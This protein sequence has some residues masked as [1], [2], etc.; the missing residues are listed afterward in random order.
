MGIEQY[1]LMTD[2]ALWEV[3]LNGDSPVSTRTV[4]GV[5]TAIPPTT[6]EQKLAKRNELNLT[7]QLDNDDLKQIDPDDLEEMDLKWQMTMLTIRARRFLKKNGRNL[8]V[9]GTNTIS[10]DKTKSNQ[11]EEGPTNF[12]LMA[13]TSLGSSSSSSLDTE[14]QL[15]IVAYKAGLES[16]EARLDVYKKNKAVFKED[17]KIL[18]LDVM[19][20]DN[21][22]TK[23][24]KKFEKAKKE[25]DDLE[26]TLEKFEKS[27]KNLSKLLNSQISDNLKSGLGYNSQGYDSK[28]SDSEVNQY[29]FSELVSSVP[30]AAT[31]KVKTSELK[32]KSVSEPIIEDWISNKNENE[33][34]SESE[35]RKPSNARI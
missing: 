18:R 32:S 13:Y 9:N 30:V 31:T 10:F 25:R 22:L 33:I 21:A 17:I 1:F 29:V 4:N 8:G 23:L 24:R 6:V 5:E 28:V 35:Q 15:N 16:V 3:I 2:Y 20:S 34:E 7:A 19:L 26:L 11:A 12:A 14:S 27:S